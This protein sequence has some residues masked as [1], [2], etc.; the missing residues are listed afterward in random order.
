MNLKFTRSVWLLAVLLLTGCGT[1]QQGQIEP[2]L[3]ADEQ[4]RLQSRIA[5]LLLEA[6]ESV[7][8]QELTTPEGDNALAHYRVVLQLQPDN[9]EARRGLDRIVDSYIAWS[10]Q[11]INQGD[12]SKSQVYLDRARLVQPDSPRIKAQQDKLT[13]LESEGLQPGVFVIDPKQ[14]K[15]R[16]TLL[17]N[18]LAEIA[19]Q[20]Q[21]QSA[22]FL[23]IAPNDRDARW[24]FQQMQAAVSERLRGNIEIGSRAQ[25]KVLQKPANT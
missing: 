13:N 14:L 4:Q 9:A 8:R 7:A 22:V 17:A 10:R 2:E 24:I 20:V 25:V 15:G 5:W 3:A 16:T 18:E 23:I 11:A 19:R 12:V 6:E 21:Q 1:F